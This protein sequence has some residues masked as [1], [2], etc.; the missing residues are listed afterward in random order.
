MPAASSENQTW[1]DPLDI[2]S[3]QQKVEEE[4]KQRNNRVTNPFDAEY[5]NKPK[6]PSEPSLPVARKKP[7]PALSIKRK[8]PPPDPSHKPSA[9]S[10]SSTKPLVNTAS[11]PST[12]LSITPSLSKPFADKQGSSLMDRQDD[13]MKRPELKVRETANEWQVITPNPMKR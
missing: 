2:A 9:T 13:E 4:Q 10:L 1:W 5:L 11:K 8:P 12:P 7:A 6:D 3:L